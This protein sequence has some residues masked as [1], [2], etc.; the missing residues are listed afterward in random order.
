MC[1]GDG[2]TEFLPSPHFQP[3]GCYLPLPALP[4][5]RAKDTEGGATFLT[6]ARRMTVYA[7]VAMGPF[8]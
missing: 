8:V 3:D 2:A 4:T 1:A 7:L 5:L 6:K